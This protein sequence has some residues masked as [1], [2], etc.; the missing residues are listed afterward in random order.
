MSIWLCSRN[1]LERTIPDPG[2]SSALQHWKHFVCGA[3]AGM[4]VQIPT[5]P[6]DTL[7]K[8]MQAVDGPPRSAASELRLLVSTGGLGRLYSGFGVKCAFVALN[9][10]IFNSVYMQCRRLMRMHS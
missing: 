7:K 1:I 6:L 10:A 5:Y 2:R 3:A 8:R 4:I 9:S